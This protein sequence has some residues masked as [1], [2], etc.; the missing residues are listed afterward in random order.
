ME[1]PVVS[2]PHREIDT[3]VFSGHRPTLIITRTGGVHVFASAPET[4]RAFPARSREGPCGPRLQRHAACEAAD[5]GHHGYTFQSI[6]EVWVFNA[7]SLG[8]FAVAVCY[9]FLDLE[10]VA[11]YRLGIQHLFILAY[12]TDLP[13]FDHAAEALSRMIFCNVVVCNTGSHGGSLAVSPYSG[14]GK[15]VIYRHI[16]SPL[17]TGQTVA[18]PVA[19]LIL[20]Q[21]NSWPSGRDREFKSLPPGAEIVHELTPYTTDI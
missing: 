7:G 2:H 3:S 18:L 4:R 16:G 15:R 1:K 9:D 21:T 6:P 14:V 5:G 11:M 20:A 17:S 8:K 10:R 13:T 12:N 19:D